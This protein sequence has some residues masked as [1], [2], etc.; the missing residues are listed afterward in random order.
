MN[1]WKQIAK[2]FRR[3]FLLWRDM[4]N[5]V[6]DVYMIDESWSSAGDSVTVCYAYKATG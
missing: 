4:Y 1:I 6:A 2:Y 3:Q 5:E